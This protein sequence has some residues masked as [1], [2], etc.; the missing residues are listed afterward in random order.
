MT[1][2]GSMRQVPESML[3]MALPSQSWQWHEVATESCWCGT[4]DATW[5]WRSAES[6]W[7]WRCQ[8]D[9][10]CG[11]M[12]LLSHAGDGAAESYWR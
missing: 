2:R 9:V 8:G 1:G 6:C 5:L 4:T 10:D 11:V 3:G 7:R 12:S